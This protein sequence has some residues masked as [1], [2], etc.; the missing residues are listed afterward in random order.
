MRAVANCHHMTAMLLLEKGANFMIRNKDGIT[1]MH[2]ACVNGNEWVMKFLWE[3]GAIKDVTSVV[4]STD[5]L[6]CC[7]QW[8]V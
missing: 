2:Y 8:C 7:L 1:A 4:S 5:L 6:C 3:K